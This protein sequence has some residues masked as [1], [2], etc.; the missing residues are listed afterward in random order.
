MKSKLHLIYGCARSKSNRS[1]I[2]FT[3]LKG[4]RLTM[5]RGGG[6]G[7]KYD[8]TVCRQL[9]GP[10]AA[11]RPSHSHITLHILLIYVRRLGTINRQ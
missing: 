7:G 3:A 9:G 11:T 4:L 10:P 5:L 2:N 8:E 1:T 6:G